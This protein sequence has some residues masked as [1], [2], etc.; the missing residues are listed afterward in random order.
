MVQLIAHEW[1]SVCV[2]SLAKN[3]ILRNSY[4]NRSTIGLSLL[5]ALGQGGLRDVTVGLKAW[6]NI[7]LPL[8]EIKSYTKYVCEYVY[9]ILHGNNQVKDS[10]A[11]NELTL[12]Y[13]EFLAIF[14]ELNKSRTGIPRD[15]QKL[16]TESAK[17]LLVSPILTIF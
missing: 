2:E 13:D 3:A 17:P 7:M 9:R 4:Q 15:C 16:L 5:W 12:Q 11:V 10:A 14:D 8:L 1:P 6:Q